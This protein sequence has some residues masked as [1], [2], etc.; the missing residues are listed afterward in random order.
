MKIPQRLLCLRKISIISVFKDI[1]SL[2]FSSSHQTEAKTDKITAV[3]MYNTFLENCIKRKVK[4]RVK[5]IGVLSLDT[6]EFN[7]SVE[8]DFLAYI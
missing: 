6:R 8:L 5:R 3:L 7:L 2:H 1:L 4:K